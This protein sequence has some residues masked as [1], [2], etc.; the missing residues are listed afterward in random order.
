[1]AQNKNKTSQGSGLEELPEVVAAS[2]EP[3]LLNIRFALGVWAAVFS[4]L[5]LSIVWD[6][7]YGLLFRSPPS[8]VG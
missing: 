8:V 3:E 6:S 2:P 5:A 1:M 4:L 7:I